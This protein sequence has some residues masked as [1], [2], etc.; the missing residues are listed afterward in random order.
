MHLLRHNTKA[1]YANFYLSS[2]FKGSADPPPLPSPY[3]ALCHH[4]ETQQN[5]Q[6]DCV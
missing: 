1:P 6:H 4:V 3:A 5:E 2:K